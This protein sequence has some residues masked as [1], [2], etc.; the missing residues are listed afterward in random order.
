MLN[1][2][3]HKVT[4]ELQR[5]TD[6]NGENY[7]TVSF[8]NRILQVTEREWAW[9][10]SYVAVL[11]VT[12]LQTTPGNPS[13][14]SP[15]VSCP[16][17]SIISNLRCVEIQTSEDA[18]NSLKTDTMNEPGSSRKWHRNIYSVG[19]KETWRARSNF[20]QMTITK[21]LCLRNRLWIR[22]EWKILGEEDNEHW[23][24]KIGDN[25]LKE[26]E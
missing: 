5:L 6:I 19:G 14:P 13:F 25:C 23:G 2:A 17:T 22:I 8:I 10:Q 1:L 20:K 9:V 15:S 3:V 4:I 21:N 24:E 26:G 16:E 12:Q 7:E 18:R 11:I